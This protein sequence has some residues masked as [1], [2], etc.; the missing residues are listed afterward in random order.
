MA[1]Y[2]S[3]EASKGWG[4]ALAEAKRMGAALCARGLGTGIPKWC[5]EDQYW[6]SCPYSRDG[7]CFT[8]K[9]QRDAAR[10]GQ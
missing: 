9:E 7:Y 3:R 1:G 5:S 10:S 6:G 2:L 4:E 8:T